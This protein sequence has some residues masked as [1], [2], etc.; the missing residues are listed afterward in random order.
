[1]LSGIDGPAYRL[2]FAA[3]KLFGQPQY[4]CTFC[5]LIRD[6]PRHTDLEDHAEPKSWL[7]L[8]QS[9]HNRPCFLL[10]PGQR[11]RRGVK[12]IKRAEAGIGLNSLGEG[13]C[14]LCSSQGKV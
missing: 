2:T 7:Q 10:A 1:M 5:E 6:G 4:A 9:P 14:R 11:Q 8:E 3:A 12:E 13:R